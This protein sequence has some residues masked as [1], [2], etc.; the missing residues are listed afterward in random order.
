MTKQKA[1]Q[2]MSPTLSLDPRVLR[3]SSLFVIPF[4]PGHPHAINPLHPS[5]RPHHPTIHDLYQSSAPIHPLA[6]DPLLPSPRPPSSPPY[7]I[8]IQS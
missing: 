3:C 2:D 1:H 6:I 7:T 5:P 8:L 4:G